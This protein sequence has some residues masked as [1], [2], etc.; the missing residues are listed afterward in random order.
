M[1]FSRQEYWSGLP[2]P[3][4]GD[5]PSPGIKPRPQASCIG[6]QVYHERHLGSLI[7]VSILPQIPLP[8]EGVSNR[9][10]GHHGAERRLG[11]PPGTGAGAKGP[12]CCCRV[13]PRESGLLLCPGLCRVHSC[14]FLERSP[15]GQAQ[16]S[17]CFLILQE[18]GA[19]QG[20]SSHIMRAK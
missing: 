18:P 6:R 17:S 8:R 14:P 11:L 20:W 12:G 3:P 19:D 7:D 9:Q 4:P 2:S 10:R 15:H 5:L 13:G 1:G 16:I